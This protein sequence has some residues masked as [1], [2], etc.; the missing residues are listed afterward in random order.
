MKV[1]PRPDPSVY[2]ERRAVEAP[3]LAPALPPANAAST[4]ASATTLS[5]TGSL[6]SS[7]RRDAAAHGIA[8]DIRPGV[9]E[10]MKREIAAGRLGSP[11]DLDRAV[12]ALLGAL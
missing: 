5:T 8:G 2:A 12:D 3:R 7:L 9:V 11:E 6:V 1:S 4:N 10:D